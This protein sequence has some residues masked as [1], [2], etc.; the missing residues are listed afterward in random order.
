MADLPSERVS[1][2]PPFLNV[3]VDFCGPFLISYPIRR[4]FPRKHFV[5]IFVCLVTKAV[6][7]ELVSDLTSEAFFAAFKRFVARRGRPVLVMCDNALNFVGAKRQLDEL[8]QLFMDQGFHDS[9]ARGAVEEGIEFRFN[10]ARSP[11]FGGLWEAAVESFKGNFKR[12]IGERMLQH[13]EC[14]QCCHK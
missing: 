10:P 5:A 8:R 3:G 4:S 1:P 13:D 2:A 9:V 7:L 12:T 14:L 6:H 11:D